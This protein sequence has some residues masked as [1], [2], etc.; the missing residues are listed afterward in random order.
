M[1]LN[2]ILSYLSC[3]TISWILPLTIP[4]SLHDDNN[5]LLID[6]GLLRAEL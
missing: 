6:L 3:L 1:E 5:A 2:L 4:P